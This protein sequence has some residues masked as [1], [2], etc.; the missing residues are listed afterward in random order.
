M[1]SKKGSK[2]ETKK[3]HK[4]GQTRSQKRS[5][6]VTK[7]LKTFFWRREG[8]RGDLAQAVPGGSREL[9]GAPPATPGARHPQLF[10]KIEVFS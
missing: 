10:V 4:F 3:S 7:F 2:E 8:V 6:E 5:F 1:T 9:P